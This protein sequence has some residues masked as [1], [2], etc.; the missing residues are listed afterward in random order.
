[1]IGESPP[2]LTA[3]RPGSARSLA[4]PFR[5]LTIRQPKE[6][7]G[8]LRLHIE[9]PSVEHAGPRAFAPETA[10]P[11]SIR[12]RRKSCS[13]LLFPFPYLGHLRLRPVKGYLKRRGRLCSA[14]DEPPSS[15]SQAS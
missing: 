10:N 9:T 3:L 13:S 4:R 6:P 15:S 12:P 5:P 1:M 14:S 11:S 8:S 7:N 2:E